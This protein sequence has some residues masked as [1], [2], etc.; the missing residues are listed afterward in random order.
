[1]TAVEKLFSIFEAQ[2]MGFTTIVVSEGKHDVAADWV[3]GEWSIRPEWLEK[4][5]ALDAPAEPAPEEAPKGKKGD[6][7]KE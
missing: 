6:K 3:N 1:M 5:S 7:T 2:D 4:I